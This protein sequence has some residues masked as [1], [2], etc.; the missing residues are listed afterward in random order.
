MPSNMTEINATAVMKLVEDA[1]NC[2][3]D[4][5]TRFALIRIMSEGVPTHL[6]IRWSAY[7][8]SWRIVSISGGEG[9]NA[10]ISNEP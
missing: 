6:D 5:I 10:Q 9:V 4:D 8:T 7:P 3:M 2:S 1:G